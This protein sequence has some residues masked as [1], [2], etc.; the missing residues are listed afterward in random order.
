ML[1]KRSFPALTRAHTHRTKPAVDCVQSALPCLINGTL[2]VFRGLL[3]RVGMVTE[4]YVGA[5]AVNGSG[6]AVLCMQEA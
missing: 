6:G 3:K 1:F 2:A 4:P 5:C